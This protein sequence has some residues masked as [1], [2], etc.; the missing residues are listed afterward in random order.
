M[1]KQTSEHFSALEAKS[2]AQKLAFAPIVFHT[3]RTLRDLG[4]LAALDSAGEPGA[5]AAQIAGSTGVSEYG[6]KVLLDMA[7]SA[8]I[9]HWNTPNYA[10]TK[11]GYFLLHDPM[12]RANMDFTADVCY[13]AMMHLTEAITDG[14]PA[15][16]K[17]LG[18][19]DTIYQGLSQ[20]PEKARESWFRFDHFYSDR[21]FPL[22]LETVLAGHPRHLVDIGGNTGKWAIQCCE[23][24]PCT[25]VT[26]VD[27]PQQLELAMEN[28]RQHNLSGR[29]YAWPANLLELGQTLSQQ[30]DI[31]WMS[32]FL[33]CFS[34]PEIVHI[35]RLVRQQLSSEDRVYIL[36]LFWDTQKYEAASYSLNA[37]SLYFTCLANGNSRFYRSDDFLQ[38][39]KEAGLEVEERTD[40]IGLGHTL[41]KLKASY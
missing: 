36:E 31:W 12:T 32:Q 16:L 27:L 26:I 1:Y 14:R 4:V 21:S 3:A 22:L 38:L 19:W 29:I 37:T 20:L 17:E 40:D 11:M 18:N 9:V 23:H 24:S 34:P 33:D 5:T 41:L 6:V 25:Q 35:L 30:A 39:I 10:L 7:I 2:E 28:A 13:A 15:G 8:S